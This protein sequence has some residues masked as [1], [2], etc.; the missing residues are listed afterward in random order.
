[1]EVAMRA[2][3]SGRGSL[4][5]R[6]KSH[7][8]VFSTWSTAGNAEGFL[9]RRSPRRAAADFVHSLLAKPGRAAVGGCL[10]AAAVAASAAA[11][12]DDVVAARRGPFEV[13]L[14][15]E[16]GFEPAGST[17]VTVRPESW[18][19][20]LEILEVAPHGA[21][22]EAGA[23]LCRFD[24][25]KIDR[26]LEDLRVELAVTMQALEIARQELAAAE[27][28]RPLDLAEA[29]R[30]NRVAVEDRA[31]FLALGRS[32]A[33]DTARFAARA[34]R[35]R[36]TYA[37]EELG[38]L[39]RMYQDKDLT[40]ET[41]E[42]ILQRTRFDVEQAEFGLRRTTAE[43]E[44]T[45]ELDVPRRAEA[46]DQG[47][48]KAA[49]RLA[50]VRATLPLELERRRLAIAKLEH[51]HGRSRRTVE[52]LGR[53]RER[54]TLRAAA[55]GIVYHGRMTDGGWSS[56]GPVAK[57]VVGQ[58]VPL[59]ELAFTVVA[60]GPLRFRAKVPESEL[61]LIR[62][63]L[64]GRVAATG[65][66][67]V[68]GE[69]TLA[70]AAAPVPKGGGFDAVFTIAFAP[71]TATWLPGM[72]GRSRFVIRG[73]ADAVTVPAAAVFR[74]GLADRVVYVARDEGD[75]ERR[76]VKVGLTSGGRTEIL[77]GVAAG[78]R[79]RTTKP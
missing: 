11:P 17:L 70:A 63:G 58:A 73:R 6:G 75:P 27:A 24:V 36:L 9:G 34:A 65:F 3:W 60:P 59:G 54:A 4:D 50:K 14:D 51:D 12:T 15:L 79:V 77:E 40:E 16:G 29:E 69:A 30:E 52:E 64:A 78:D 44:E 26:A 68:F 32:L 39:E 71:A 25:E 55:A 42:M 47:A 22:V 21:A 56:A 62:P 41:E 72:T 5:V 37:R 57:A 45:L 66:P 19:Q 7:P 13:V 53:D 74:E 67:D 18:S 8:W 1:L 61:H 35:Q 46:L 38:Q 33:E 10:V 48:E 49:L 23:V 2:G 43:T 31:R 20:P 28:L 76:L